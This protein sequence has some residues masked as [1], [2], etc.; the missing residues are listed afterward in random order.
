[1]RTRKA[2]RAGL[3]LSLLIIGIFVSLRFPLVHAAS[4]TGPQQVPMG[5][6]LYTDNKITFVDNAPSVG[7]PLKRD[8]LVKFF[9]A[10]GNGHWDPGEPLAYD[11]N[12][13]SIMEGIK[14]AIAGSIPLGNP[15]KADPLI[16]FVD[17]NNENH[18]NA[19]DAIVYDTN[20]NNL[21]DA[22]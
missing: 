22:G 15:L 6:T 9:D 18:W 8:S 4:F 21:Y 12:N 14:P 3:L 5:T 2:S 13:D 11:S 1:M 7:T 16:K 17:T 20:N 10:N 19:G